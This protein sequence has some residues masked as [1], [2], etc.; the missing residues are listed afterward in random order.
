MYFHLK[1]H[2]FY[3]C[4]QN[5]SWY[6]KNIY[7][8]TAEAVHLGESLAGRRAFVYVLLLRVIC[9]GGKFYYVFMYLKTARNEI[10]Q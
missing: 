7:T 4:P 3:R 2:E 1:L 9:G 6:K 10:L 5:V 8:D